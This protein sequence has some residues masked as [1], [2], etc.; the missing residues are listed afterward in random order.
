MLGILILQR[1]I[2]KKSDRKLVKQ[3]TNPEEVTQEDKEFISDLQMM[4]LSFP[5]KNKI[6]ARLR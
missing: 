6:L 5:C 3:L 2:H 1:N 4:E